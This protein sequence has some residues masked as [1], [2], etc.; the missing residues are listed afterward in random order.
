MEPSGSTH[1]RRSA[2]LRRWLSETHTPVAE[3]ALRLTIGSLRVDTEVIYRSPTGAH[4]FAPI[5]VEGGDS[6]VAACAEEARRR[7]LPDAAINAADAGTPVEWA[8]SLGPDPQLPS[9]P[10]RS[11]H[12]HAD[13]LLK[14]DDPAA[15]ARGPLAMIG[16]FGRAGLA[17]E[18]EL[19]GLLGERLRAA[20][21]RRL[22]SPTTADLAVLVGEDLRYL[23]EVTPVRYEVPNPLY[24]GDPEVPGVPIP[25]LGGEWSL[26]PADTDADV[27]LVHR[28]M[29]SEHVAVNWHQDWPLERWRE[30]IATQLGGA[31]SVPCVVALNGR[32]IAYVELYRVCRDK[33]AGCYPYAPHD[34]G[35]H[36][37]VGERDAIGRGVGSA[38]LRAVAD[39]LLA[40][41]PVCERVV[42]EPNVHNGAS[43]GAFGRA[44]FV[45][46]RE[47]G[48]P[49]K[50][51][52]LM[53]F[54]R[55]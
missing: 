29:N 11:L 23:P 50:N 30:E 43:V 33:L 8:R 34:L 24:A 12:D 1:L 19:L 37:A 47:V 32:E 35:V 31:H 53:V 9:D 28:W 13:A 21:S 46:E 54:S 44:G 36:I 14:S 39:G 2:V 3:G 51:S 45:R 40:A 18:D 42:A 52:A 4:A 41:D 7:S 49:A 5:S 17:D 6:L 38:L 25:E 27:A 16:R 26:R 20:G 10:V 15:L 48:L 22:D 55:R